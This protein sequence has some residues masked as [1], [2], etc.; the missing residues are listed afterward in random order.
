[1]QIVKKSSYNGIK[2]IKPAG[3]GSVKLN[4]QQMKTNKS[5]T[6]IDG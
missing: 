3:A 2:R 4:R 6:G 5:S 1:M